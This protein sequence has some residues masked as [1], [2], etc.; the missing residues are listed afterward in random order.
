[1]KKLDRYIIREMTI[2]FIAGTIVVVLLFQL[3]TLIRIYKEFNVAAL[4]FNAVLQFI[5]FQTPEY[6]SMTLPVG[7]A[8]ASSLAMSRFGREHELVAMRSAGI[9]ILR[10]VL[11]VIFAGVVVSIANFYIVERAQAAFSV[12]ALKLQSEFGRA[13]APDLVENVT[14]RLTDYTATFRRSSRR[15]DGGIDVE[16]A[17]LLQR[18]GPGEIWIITA[19]RGTYL[20]GVWNFVLPVARAI[21]GTDLIYVEPKKD[22][23]IRQKV[24]LPEMSLQPPIDQQ[25]IAELARTIDRLKRQK[26]KTTVYEIAYHRKFSMP[27]AC[28]IL[29]LTAAVFSIWLSRKGPFVGVLISLLMVMVYYNLYIV[30]LSILAPKGWVSPAVAAWIPNALFLCCG[31]YGLRRL[32]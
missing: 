25:P 2:P 27:A 14:L 18:P 11:P 20:D 10:I 13:I 23:V 26:Q 21:K 22:L 17:M 3:N 7:V 28:A 5:L 15:K 6:L 12:R 31:I 9:S 8:L 16:G 24:S 30:C 1:M 29:A 4:P 32:G 19:E